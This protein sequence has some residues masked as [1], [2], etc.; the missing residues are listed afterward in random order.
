MRRHRVPDVELVLVG[1]PINAA[2]RE[3]LASLAEQLAPGAV[4]IESSLSDDALAA[5]YREAGAFVSLSEHEGFCVP[6]LEAFDFGVPVVARPSGGVPEV[7]G[8]AAL[9]ADDR[10]PAVLA[11]LV[12]L[13]LTDE[14]L[15]GALVE[16]GRARLDAYAPEQT[17]RTMRAA[18]EAL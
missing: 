5:R 1:E 13:A 2:Y 6:L 8:D 9:L 7:A 15:R 12:A 18:L 10:D 3:A 14:E 11:E 4:T 17:A 16:R